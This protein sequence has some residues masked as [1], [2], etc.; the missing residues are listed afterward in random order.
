MLKL[1]DNVDYVIDEEMLDWYLSNGLR[2]ENVTIRQKLELS[3][4]ERL[5][6]FIE[7][8]IQ[9]RKEDKAKGDKF[10][11]VFFKLIVYL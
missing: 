6:P 5:K 11:D 4:S 1:T 7:F 9:K 3:K 2:L 8:K 10:G